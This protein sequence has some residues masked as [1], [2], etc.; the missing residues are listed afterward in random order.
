MSLDNEMFIKAAIEKALK[1]NPNYEL[2]TGEV[3]VFI[4]RGKVTIKD[5]DEYSEL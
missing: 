5:T 1:E 4:N 3:G 2:M